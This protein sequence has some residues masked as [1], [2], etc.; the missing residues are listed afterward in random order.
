MESLSI[1]ELVVA[2]NGTLVNGNELDEIKKIVID[3]RAANEGDAFM[4]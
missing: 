2:S 3:S 4:L 1:K